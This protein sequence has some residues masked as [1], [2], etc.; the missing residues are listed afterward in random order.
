MPCFTS[1]PAF[2]R[3]TELYAIPGVTRSGLATSPPRALKYATASG[4]GPSGPGTR[5]PDGSVAPTVMARS[6]EP[7]SPIVLSPGPSLP[8]LIVSDTSGCAASTESARR[9]IRALPF[10]LVADAEAEV[11]H[12]R[13]LPLRGEADGVVHRADHG[14][15]GR[16]AALRAERDLEAEEL[17]ARRHPVESLHAVEVVRARRCPPRGCRG[18]RDRT[19]GRGW[20]RWPCRRSW[21]RSRAR[22]YA[23]AEPSRSSPG[24]AGSRAPDARR[25]ASRRR[26]YRPAA[27]SR[28][29]RAPPRPAG[30]RRWPRC[31]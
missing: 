24:P 30:S 16:D 3:G 17:R 6:A 10:L 27:P 23:R 20:A 13:H 26:R 9:S 1:S 8:P 2:H 4:A 25:P 21:R 28:R 14:A 7:G 18:R 19:S 11:H 22:A 29:W 5:N 31:R 15:G 12:Q